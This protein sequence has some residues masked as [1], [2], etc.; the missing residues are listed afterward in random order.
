MP[1]PTL[2]TNE[3][4]LMSPRPTAP[5]VEETEDTAAADTEKPAPEA[6]SDDKLSEV[7][8]GLNTLSG[9]VLNLAK[10]VERLKNPNI[11]PP[12]EDL[13]PEPL[14][15]GIVRFWSKY[16]DY[17]IFV[18]DEVSTEIDGEIVIRK[19]RPRKASKSGKARAL[20]FQDRILDIDLSD[21]G[22]PELVEYLT[23]HKDYGV[24][25]FIDPTAKAQVT[26]LD[27]KVGIRGAAEKAEEKSPLSATF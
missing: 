3:G 4:N 25:F 22:S 5:K 19:V 11:P 16:R 2:T 15:E 26:D 23:S 7:L 13:A 18:E 9:V 8:A 20:Q 24:D 6:S 12:P 17:Q 14:P 1:H 10:D 21:E 27:V